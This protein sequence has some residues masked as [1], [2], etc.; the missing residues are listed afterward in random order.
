[1]LYGIISFL[2]N[3]VIVPFQNFGQ[4]NFIVEEHIRPVKKNVLKFDGQDLEE[5]F[6]KII[7]AITNADTVKRDLI[8]SVFDRWRKALYHEEE[9]E[10]NMVYTDESVLAYVHVLEVLSDEF[11][12]QLSKNLRSRKKAVLDQIF[13]YTNSSPLPPSKEIRKLVIEYSSLQV[14]LREKIEI[15]LKEFGLYDLKTAAVVSRFIEHRNSI[16]HGRKDVYKEKIIFPL[17]PFFSLVNDIDEHPELIKCLSAKCISSYLGLKAW[18]LEWQ[19]LLLY[20]FTPLPLVKTFIEEKRF[21]NI[22]PSDFLKGTI[23]GIVPLTIYYHFVK[24]RISSKDFEESLSAIFITIKISKKVAQQLFDSAII[25]ADSADQIVADKAR[26][27]IERVDKNRWGGYSNIRDILKYNE[28][29]GKNM[30]WFKTY[31]INRK[32]GRMRR[33]SR[34]I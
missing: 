29:H 21:Q 2:T 5:D 30:V 8:Y 32:S 7:S 4:A 31:L 9:S 10:D 3:H 23:D 27:I 11:K 22:Q 18:D 15:M 6:D 26:Q 28:Y 16:A 20:E 34:K 1:M 13:S 24:G 14:T 25:L 19:Y 17:P 33:S 12:T